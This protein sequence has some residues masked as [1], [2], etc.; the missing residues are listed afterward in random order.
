MVK[1]KKMG[2]FDLTLSTFVQYVE[3]FRFWVNASGRASRLPE[4]EMAKMF[5]TGLKTDLFREKIYSRSCET[6]QEAMDESRAEL[7]TY[8]DILEI[9]DRVKRQM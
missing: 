7:S 5:V 2:K 1:N 6:L 8:C 3:D 4:K 9:T